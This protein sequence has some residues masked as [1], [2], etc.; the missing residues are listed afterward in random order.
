MIANVRLKVF[1]QEKLFPLFSFIN[2]KIVHDEHM[3]MFYSN[4][5]PLRDNSAPPLDYMLK[6]G[7]NKYYKRSSKYD[8]RV[9]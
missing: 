1:L 4:I 5:G 6:K 9:N 8:N 3:I 2:K 7:C